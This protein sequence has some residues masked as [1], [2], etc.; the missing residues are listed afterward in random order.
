LVPRWCAAWR[1]ARLQRWRCRLRRCLLKNLVA[2]PAAPEVRAFAWERFIDSPPKTLFPIVGIDDAESTA[3]VTR[4]C[5]RRLALSIRGYVFFP[6][7]S[8]RRGGGR[9][10]G[11]LVLRKKKG[12]TCFA[13]FEPTN[14][15]NPSS[16]RI[17]PITTGRSDAG[18]GGRGG[19]GRGGGRGRG[20]RGRG[21]GSPF[22][23]RPQSDGTSHLGKGRRLYK[24][25]C[26]SCE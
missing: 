20:G 14:P 22:K 10:G 19:G 26:T 24:L 21:R 16:S 2:S 17:T 3:E 1:R 11:V 25:C 12:S 6:S 9:K 18:R 7:S 23:L 8:S 4:A 13:H 5:A 15:T